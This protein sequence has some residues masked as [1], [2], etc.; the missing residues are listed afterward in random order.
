MRLQHIIGT[1]IVY[2]RYLKSTNKNKK[3]SKKTSVIGMIINYLSNAIKNITLI[4]TYWYFRR[5]KM[6]VCISMYVFFHFQSTRYSCDR[7]YLWLHECLV[8]FPHDTMTGAPGRRADC[9]YLD[10]VHV[11]HLSL[12]RLPPQVIDMP[13]SSLQM[14]FQT[15]SR[16]NSF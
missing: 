16:L 13:C 10:G 7:L 12:L 8:T 6:Y 2:N 15:M 1:Y 9:F 5:E 11:C 3:Q 14:Y 4:S